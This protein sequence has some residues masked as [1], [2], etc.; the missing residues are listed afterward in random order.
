[1]DLMTERASADSDTP[2]ERA[3]VENHS[4][5]CADRRTVIDGS[6]DRAERH[7]M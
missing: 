2:R 5:S 7:V 3:R 1:M 6:G 4:L